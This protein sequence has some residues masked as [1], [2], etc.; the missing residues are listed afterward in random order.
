MLAIHDGAIE[1]LAERVERLLAEDTPRT[2]FLRDLTVFEGYHERLAEATRRA[3]RG[4]LA[5]S[6]DEQ[7]DPDISFLAYL[8][9][10][11]R[12]P[13]TPEDTWQALLSGRYNVAE[14]LC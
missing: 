2:R 7:R 10:C 5:L 8:A 12:Q 3:L 6:D 14:G 4:D 9:W 1:E 13:A 11:A